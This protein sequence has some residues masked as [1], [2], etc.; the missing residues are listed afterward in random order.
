M[1]NANFTDF[2]LQ[3]QLHHSE[4]DMFKMASRMVADKFNKSVGMAP[5][6]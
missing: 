5:Y 1:L 3:T 4:F 2:E 6:L